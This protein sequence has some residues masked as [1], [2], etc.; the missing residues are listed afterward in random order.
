MYEDDLCAGLRLHAVEGIR[1]SEWLQLLQAFPGP[2]ACIGAGRRAWQATGVSP[3]VVQLLDGALAAP[4][5][6]ASSV[7][8][9]QQLEVQCVGI[10]SSAYPAL[11]RTLADPP[12]WLW[13]RGR[14]EALAMPQIALVGARKASALG[15]RAA[16]ELAAGLSTA[17]LAVTSGMALGVDGAAHRG[18]LQAG[19]VTVAVL[20]TGIDQIYPRRHGVLAAEIV[21]RGCL[22]SEFA[23]GSG[24]HRS[25]FPKRNRLISGMSLGTLVVEAALPSGSLLTAQSALEQG[26][27][28]FAVPWSIYHP[29]GRGC[30]QL[31]CD[32]AVLVQQPA[33]VLSNL[34]W[35]DPALAAGDQQDL[36]AGLEQPPPAVTDLALQLWARLSDAPQTADELAAALVQP[37]AA[38]RAALAELEL[39]AA[40]A[41]HAG[42]Y[43][44]S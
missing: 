37:I 35:Y 11:L 25:H 19:G 44:R 9:L 4:P 33:D 32:G 2:G 18:A 42:G 17:G 22:V 28:V 14:L 16:T 6:A 7:R 34:G 21:Q 41:Q 31:L 26:R 15:L 13:L 39:S 8:R 29:G 36:L 43:C 12:P 24:P 1:R 5:P 10:G 40:A 38:V 30:L 20:G 27:E 3:S 23:P